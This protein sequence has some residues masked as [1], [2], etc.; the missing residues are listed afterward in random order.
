MVCYTL[1]RCKI[2]ISYDFF[3]CSFP[4]FFLGCPIFKGLFEEFPGFFFLYTS[5]FQST[6]TVRLLVLT[7]VVADRIGVR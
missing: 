1:L 4:E 2:L 7:G 5:Q 6:S 3:F